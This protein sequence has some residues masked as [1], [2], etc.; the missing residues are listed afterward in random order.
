[1]KLKKEGNKKK[2]EEMKN[3]TSKGKYMINTED[4]LLKLVWRLKDK[5]L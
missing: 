1:M 4:Q 3:P 2:L 5:K